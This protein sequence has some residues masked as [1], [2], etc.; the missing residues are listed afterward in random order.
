MGDLLGDLYV[1]H[2]GDEICVKNDNTL[3]IGFQNVGGFPA[4]PGKLKE[5]NIRLGLKKWDFDVFGVAKVNLDWRTL[6]EHDRL[7]HRT[8]EWWEH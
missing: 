7:P 3:R 8:K 4:S 1:G 6:K 2:F 5:D